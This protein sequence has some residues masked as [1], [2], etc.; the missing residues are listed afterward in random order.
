MLNNTAIFKRILPFLA[1]FIFSITYAGYTVIHRSSAPVKAEGED[2]TVSVTNIRAPLST[3]D[4]W[5]WNAIVFVKNYFKEPFTTTY[6]V[7]WCGKTNNGE[8]S[9]KVPCEEDVVG[10]SFKGQLKKDSIQVQAKDTIFK[11]DHQSVQ[12][13]RVDVIIEGLGQLLARKTYDTPT[14]C[15][16]NLALNAQGSAISADGSL[17]VSPVEVILDLFKFFN[18]KAPEMN[19]TGLPVPT[20][21]PPGSPLPTLPQQGPV[22]NCSPG[23][24][25]SWAGCISEQLERGV[26]SYYNRM[27]SDISNNGY[28]ATKRQGLDTS[29]GPTG[30]FWCTNM[31]IS[32]YSLEVSDGRPLPNLT[33]QS[34]LSMRR[35]FANTP[36]YKYLDFRNPGSRKQQLGQV[37]PGDV[38]I[39]QKV[40]DQHTQQHVAI[41]KNIHVDGNCNGSVETIDA[42]SY[43][44]VN[45]YTIAGCN[46]INSP[47]PVVAYAGL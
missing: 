20:G 40:F 11:I 33:H 38:Q 15:P 12:C 32:A 13:G 10:G 25:V 35:F 31:I 39:M 6:T 46:V 27:V 21:P 47:Y 24:I 44:K 2:I 41:V 30:L 5:Q 19:D 22:V 1:L 42:N 23:S 16:E 18:L 7:N 3:T 34:V 9:E 17:E 36:S 37:R 14:S 26:W 4:T 43:N 29:T 45:R 28:T 8:D